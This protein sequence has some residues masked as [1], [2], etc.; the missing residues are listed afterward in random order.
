MK[1][2]GGDDKTKR[3]QTGIEGTKSQKSQKALRGG[4]ETGSLNREIV[5]SLKIHPEI[6]RTVKFFFN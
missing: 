5:E 3:P 6:Y 2:S 4:R 1:V